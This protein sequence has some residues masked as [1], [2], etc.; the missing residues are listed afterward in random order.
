MKNMKIIIVDDHPLFANSLA[1]MISAMSD[2]EIT[3]TFKNGLEF[4]NFLKENNS[5]SLPNIIL[6]DINMPILNGIETMS[7]IKKN[8]P[9]L[10]VIA[11]S[12]N[13][14]EKVVLKM[15]K[16]GVKGYLLKDCEPET[17]IEALNIVYKKGF[18]Y[19]DKISKY[20]FESILKPKKNLFN[21]KEL[22]FI[23]YSCSELTYKE[24]A[25]KMCVSFKTVDNY[26]ES[27]FDRL[28]VKTR[29][30]VVIY[31]TKNKLI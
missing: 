21:D 24:I 8:M 29:I 28:N 1:M 19:S 15:V 23:K 9:K 4:I 3:H 2:F 10:D 6:L 5:E 18:F 17:F 7:W 26:R 16:L 31:A 22:D 20:I 11:L 27:V 30:G 25:E 13:D 12:V 14:D